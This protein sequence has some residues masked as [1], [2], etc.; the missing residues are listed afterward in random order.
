MLFKDWDGIMGYGRV[1]GV[2]SALR[3][4]FR[5]SCP[6]VCFVDLKSISPGSALSPRQ[7]VWYEA[8]R[9]PM[10]LSA[11][12]DAIVWVKSLHPPAMPLA[13]LLALC[14]TPYRLRY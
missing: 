14:S 9:A 2:S 11:G 8:E 13:A 12:F 3:Q 1:W 4:N 7:T 6:A 10:T 5:D